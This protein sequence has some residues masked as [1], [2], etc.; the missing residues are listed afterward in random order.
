MAD[1]LKVVDTI[2]GI[3]T[4]GKVGDLSR[5]QQQVANQMAVIEDRKQR[6]NAI[7]AEFVDAIVKI[8]QNKKVYAKQIEGKYFDTGSKFGWL[9]ANLEMALERDDLKDDLNQL[10][11]NLK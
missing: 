7:Q 3:E 5:A 1:W 2:V 4:L 6:D 9:K 10:I 8:M 11:K